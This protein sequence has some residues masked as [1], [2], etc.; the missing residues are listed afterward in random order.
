MAQRKKSPGL[1]DST[2]QLNLT[3]P[4]VSTSGTQGTLPQGAQSP[5]SQAAEPPPPTRPMIPPPAMPMSAPSQLR[6]PT[7]PNPPMDIQRLLQ[8]LMQR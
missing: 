7:A 2:Q 6:P 3:P 1:T 4:M 8:M 5:A